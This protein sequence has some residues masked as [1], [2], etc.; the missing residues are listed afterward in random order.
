[1]RIFVTGASGWIGA[2][3]IGELRRAGHDVLGLARS[4]ASAVKVGALGAEVHRGDLDD[5]DSLA[6]GAAAAD[7]VVHLAY[8]H[9]FTQMEAAAKTDL[10]AIEAM[11]SALEGTG[12]PFLFAS[13][14]AGLAPGRVATEEDS[15][16]PGHYPRSANAVAATALAERDVRVVAVRF[17]P[18]VHGPGDPGFVATLVDIARER[19]V[20]G[21]VGDG[22]NRWPA[23]H[24][25]DAADLV[26]RAV[27]DAPAGTA[28]HAIAEEGVSTREI[29]AA[30][31]RG[32]DLPVTSIPPE[33]A[34]DHFGWMGSFVGADIP[35]SST[36]T[37]E[38]FG[39]SPTHPGLIADLDAG[40]YVDAAA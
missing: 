37:R 39:W 9:D 22:A 11:G 6:A 18:S 24:R 35:A 38:R 19:G 26:R 31:G 40:A 29:A 23:V 17:A 4:D 15:P 8:D 13:G 2:A 1:M 20:A 34:N 16:D 3:V 7:G 5:T 10:A 12:A 21:Y 30:I 28:V 25:L 36:I 14:T 33:Q 27:E 32:L